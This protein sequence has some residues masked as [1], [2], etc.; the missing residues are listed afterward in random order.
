MVSVDPEVIAIDGRLRSYMRAAL[1]VMSLNFQRS[2]Y[3]LIHAYTG[4]SGVLAC[5]QVRYPVVVSY[6]GYDLDRLSGG[7]GLKSNAERFLFRHLSHFVASTIAQSTRN[8]L[9]VP[10]RARG[11]T[12][13]VPNGVDRRIFEP[14][15][16]ADARLMLGW[17]GEPTVL[18]PA[19]PSREEKRFSLAQD[20]VDVARRR[21]PSLKLVTLSDVPPD[22]VPVWMNAADVLLL[23]STGEGSPNVVKEAMACNLPVVSVDVGDVREIVSG[24]RHCHVCPDDPHALAAAITAVVSPTKR[25][26]GRE[27]SADLRL[28]QIAERIRRVYEEAIQRAPGPFGFLEKRARSSAKGRTPPASEGTRNGGH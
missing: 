19:D 21:L 28:E 22:E 4:H 27:R 25:S 26:D 3:D 14:M 5:L 9:R 6:V 15:S 20:A 17:D 7:R 8:A 24:A 18:F 2:S 16:R 23:T 13:V 1:W 12:T 10:S 11:R